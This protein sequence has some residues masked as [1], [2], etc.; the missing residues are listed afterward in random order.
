[1]KPRKKYRPG[2]VLLDPVGHVL[3][4]FKPLVQ[5]KSTT[6]RL[7]IG[8]HG[9]LDLLRRGKASREE[10]LCLGDT[11][12]MA[13]AMVH[14]TGIGVEYLP[15]IHAAEMALQALGKRDKF[16][17]LG[18]ELTALN[19]LAEIH[20]AQFKVVTVAEAEKALAYIEERVRRAARP[21]VAGTVS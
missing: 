16:I 3:T 4:G 21:A 10:I 2:R 11:I 5:I 9:A 7:K 8:Y 15:E 20:D 12:N 14:I 1:M 13:E 6:A 18:V 19:R 17:A